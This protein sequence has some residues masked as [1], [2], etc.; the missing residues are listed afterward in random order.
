MSPWRG[1]LDLG[2]K[3]FVNGTLDLTTAFGNEGVPQIHE[4]IRGDSPFDPVRLRLFG[5]VAFN[6]RLTLFNQFLIDPDIRFSPKSFLRSYRGPF[7][8]GGPS[9]KAISSGPHEV[10]V[11]VEGVAGSF[12]PP[13]HGIRY[14][15][16]SAE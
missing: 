10:I 15:D 9:Q 12:V 8:G 5:D 16:G 13:V 1:S 6:R 11:H 14:K 7:R 3:V 4:F 2:S